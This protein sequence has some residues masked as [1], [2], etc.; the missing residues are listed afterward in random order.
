MHTTKVIVS[1]TAILASSLMSCASFT[2]SKLSQSLQTPD[3]SN[4]ETSPPKPQPELTPDST[5]PVSDKSSPTSE[6]ILNEVI[7]RQKSLQVCNFEF[8][9]EAARKSSQVYTNN[10]GQ[11]LVQLLCFMAAYQGA[12]T[13]LEVD[14]TQPEL[15][16][17]P[18]ELEVAGFPQF[19]S[20]TKILSNAY[21]FTG[22]GTCIQETQHYW[23]GDGLR[24]VSSQLIDQVPNGCQEAGARSPSAN[25]LITPKNVGSAKLSMTLG[26]LKQVLGEGATFEPT[27]LGVDAGEGIKVTQDGNVQYLLGFAQ[28]KPITNNSQITMITVENPNYRTSAGVGAG[29]PL[30]EAITAYGQATL[31][32]NLNNEGREYIKFARGLGAD[33]GVLIRSNQW[34]ITEFAG[35]YPDPQSEFNQTQKYQDHAAIG[36]ITIRQ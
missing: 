26:E 35:I 25:Q 7:S 27:P 3:S 6:T 30:K 22:A 9:S 28:G 13:F 20:K 36:S 11:H 12:F 8:D 23:N 33:T 18:L 1:L 21:K 32:Y 24:L 14:T 19:D 29:T 5:S 16:I 2:E 34:T 31:S 15:K 10:Q 17:K 4:T